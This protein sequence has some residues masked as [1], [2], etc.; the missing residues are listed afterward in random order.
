[1]RL[2]A[3]GRDLLFGLGL[4]EGQIPTMEVVVSVIE[5]SSTK[6]V[7]QLLMVYLQQIARRSVPVTSV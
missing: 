5:P 6:M 3:F 4:F 7:V 2:L 1:M